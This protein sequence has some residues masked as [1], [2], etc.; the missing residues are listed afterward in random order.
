VYLRIAAALL[1]LSV[2]PAFAAATNSLAF[3]SVPTLDDLGLVAVT[4]A[5]GIAGGLAARRRKK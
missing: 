1:A 3:I 4:L 5:V 2:S